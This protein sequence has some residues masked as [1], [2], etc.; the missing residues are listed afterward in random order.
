V[1]IDRGKNV[2]P[3]IDVAVSDRDRTAVCLQYRHELEGEVCSTFTIDEAKIMTHEE[4][5]KIVEE[6]FPSIQKKELIE[7]PYISKLD[8]YKPFRLITGA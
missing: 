8:C 2:P 7:G 4:F 1:N 3:K 5:L 6:Y